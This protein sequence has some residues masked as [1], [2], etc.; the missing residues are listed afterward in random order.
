M[1]TVVQ[2]IP[3]NTYSKVRY[4][5]LNCISP[6]CVSAS[7]SI[8]PRTHP[9]GF[10]IESAYISEQKLSVFLSTERSKPQER[11]ALVRQSPGAPR[12]LFSLFPAALSLRRPARRACTRW[13]KLRGEQVEGTGVC[14]PELLFGEKAY[15]ALCSPSTAPQ[16]CPHFQKPIDRI[17]FLWEGGRLFFKTRNNHASL[18]NLQLQ[19]LN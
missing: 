13:L 18:D 8:T 5:L 2:F 14:I 10:E 9:A 17:L 16:G 12:G 6:A 15:S 11:S 19:L 4:Q 7:A 3:R 1:A